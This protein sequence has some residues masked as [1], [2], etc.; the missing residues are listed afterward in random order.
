MS[1]VIVA[2]ENQLKR[3]DLR[4]TMLLL[5]NSTNENEADFMTDLDNIYRDGNQRQKA[6]DNIESKAAQHES[7]GRD[8]A[9]LKPLRN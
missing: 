6:D 7:T 2:L 5:A 9:F 8:N 4:Q 1:L 3:A